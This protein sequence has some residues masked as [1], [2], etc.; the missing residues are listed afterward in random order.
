MEETNLRKYG[1][2]VALNNPDVYAKAQETLLL[3]GTQKCSSQQFSIY[4][5]IKEYYEDAEE[6][7]LNK[8]ISRCSAD[9]SL[10]LKGILIDIEYDCDYW[11]KDT[12]ADRRRD[13]FFKKQGYKILRIKS[14]RSIPTIEEIDEVIQILLNSTFK[15]KEIIMPDYKNTINT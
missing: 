14:R 3:H 1:Y 5:M 12:Q 6:C 2:K 4:K 15:Y 9:I 13:E 10:R 8:P 7:I 11:H